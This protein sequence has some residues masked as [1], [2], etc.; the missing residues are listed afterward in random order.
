LTIYWNGL[1]FA[2]KYSKMDFESITT[3]QGL[4]S[5]RVNCMTKDSLGFLWYG[6][7]VGL[8]RSDGTTLETFKHDPDNIRTIP[9]NFILRLKVDKSGIIWGLTNEG[10]IF[11]FN[12]YAKNGQFITNFSNSFGNSSAGAITVSDEFVFAGIRD[13]TIYRWNDKDLE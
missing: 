2:Q 5:N 7:T 4:P 13:G 10:F 12:P 6:T 11:S 1:F 9:S 3:S 8:V